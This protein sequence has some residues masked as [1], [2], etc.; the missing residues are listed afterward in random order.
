MEGKLVISEERKRQVEAEIAELESNLTRLRPQAGARETIIRL[1]KCL[2][3]AR[4]HLRALN[5][6]LGAG[7]RKE[8]CASPVF[9]FNFTVCQ[10][11]RRRSSFRRFHARPYHTVGLGRLSSKCRRRM[12]WPGRLVSWPVVRPHPD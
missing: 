2:D 7:I 9:T 6:S 11:C 1:E 8:V 5:E 10:E 12:V 4:R 3:I